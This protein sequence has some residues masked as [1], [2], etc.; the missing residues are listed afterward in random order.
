MSDRSVTVTIRTEN[1]ALRGYGADD[2][3]DNGD[4]P[5][6][7]DE[8]ARLLREAAD[9]IEQGATARPLVDYNGNIVG[10]FDVTEDPQ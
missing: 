9:W 4:N 1:A 8:V 10:R 3:N 2:D 5:L 7:R 6:N